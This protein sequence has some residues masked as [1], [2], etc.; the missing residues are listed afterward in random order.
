MGAFWCL[1]T[2]VATWA[3]HTGRWPFGLR[4][5]FVAMASF[6]AMLAVIAWRLTRRS[7]MNLVQRRLLI[8]SVTSNLAA[9]GHWGLAW[10]TGMALADAL[11]LYLL[12]AGLL[13]V[14]QAVMLDRR[15]LLTGLTFCVA[16]PLVLLWP[17]LKMEIFGLSVLI[18]LVAFGLRWT[19]QVDEFEI[20]RAHV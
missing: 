18:G 20:G 12:W 7:S 8:G 15:F 17:S 13:W 2:G 1:V 19:G 3:D 10:W 9:T 16:A 4:E 11:A 14:L 5:A 6:L